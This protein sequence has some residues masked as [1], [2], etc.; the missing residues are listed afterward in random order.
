[1]GESSGT[2]PPGNH[3]SAPAQTVLN[4]FFFVLQ[5]SLDTNAMYASVDLQK[6]ELEKQAR[7]FSK[8]FRCVTPLSPSRG[9]PEC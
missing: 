8:R 6:K 3:W 5:V 9:R 2:P 7:R 4:C 1:M